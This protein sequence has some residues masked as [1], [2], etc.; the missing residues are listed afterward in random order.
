MEL[1]MNKCILCT[2][3]AEERK[4]FFKAKPLCTMHYAEY[5]EFLVDEMENK[6][7]E[8]D[9]STA[10]NSY[11]LT[12]EPRPLTAKERADKVKK[13]EERLAEAKRLQEKKNQS[14]PEPPSYGM[15]M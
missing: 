13:E 14:Y 15:S 3:V 9:A 11:K 5:M 10:F 1:K 7:T 4:Y 6:V 12:L 8:E 2:D